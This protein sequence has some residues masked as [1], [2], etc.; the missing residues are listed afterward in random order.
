MT[1]KQKEKIIPFIQLFAYSDLI[2]K[3]LLIIGMIM[4]ICSGILFP[5]MYYMYGQIVGIVISL[6]N[7]KTQPNIW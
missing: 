5:I 6:Q 4:A 1:K 2:D 3:I 7:N